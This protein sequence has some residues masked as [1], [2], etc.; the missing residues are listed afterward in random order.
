MA[1]RVVETVFVCSSAKY[2]NNP[3][4]PVIR[5]QLS[6]LTISPKILNNTDAEDTTCDLLAGAALLYLDVGQPQILRQAAESFFIDLSLSHPELVAVRML[7]V[8]SSL[9]ALSFSRPGLPT[10]KVSATTA[11]GAYE[12]A[13]FASSVNSEPLHELV[14]G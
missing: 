7:E 2:K 5:L 8:Q 14:N 3:H 13:F 12:E 4:D 10:V 6:F 1:D 9:S 11:L